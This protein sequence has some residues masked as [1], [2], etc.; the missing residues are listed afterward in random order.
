[1][2]FCVKNVPEISQRGEERRVIGTDTSLAPPV[3]HTPGLVQEDR[4]YRSKGRER[5]GK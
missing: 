4:M 2:E 1:M 5:E 3:F